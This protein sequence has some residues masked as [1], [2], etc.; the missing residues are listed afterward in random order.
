MHPF[1]EKYGFEIL[2]RKI[3]MQVLILGYLFIM[4]K[5]LHP[6]LFI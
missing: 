2:Q 1:P 5:G 4:V 6:L 3:G